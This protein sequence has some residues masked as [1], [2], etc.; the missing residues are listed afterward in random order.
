MIVRTLV[1]TAVLIPMRSHHRI[2]TPGLRIYLGLRPLNIPIE[3]RQHNAKRFAFYNS[4]EGFDTCPPYTRYKHD[5]RGNPVEYAGTHTTTP[6]DE[7]TTRIFLR[8]L[9]TL[10]PYG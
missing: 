3:R 7:F 6:G 4:T 10:A 9:N 1:E 8:L 5:G 2:L